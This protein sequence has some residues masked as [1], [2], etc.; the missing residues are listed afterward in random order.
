MTEV[1]RG[2]RKIS[3]SENLR[4]AEFAKVQNCGWESTQRE[5]LSDYS[6]AANTMETGEIID[7]GNNEPIQVQYIGK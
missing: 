5:M 1:K 7:T 2:R 3:P 4:P 6:E